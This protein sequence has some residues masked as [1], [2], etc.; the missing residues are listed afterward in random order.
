MIKS[1]FYFLKQIEWIHYDQKL[2]FLSQNLSLYCVCLKKDVI[3][4]EIVECYLVEYYFA[5]V[6]GTEPL[7]S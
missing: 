6:E 7:V 4:N 3:N 2:F 5:L 1:C